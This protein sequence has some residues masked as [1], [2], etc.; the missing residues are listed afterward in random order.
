MIS[1]DLFSQIACDHSEDAGNLEAQTV[2]E[3][4]SLLQEFI[5]YIKQH[6]VVV[7]EELASAF[8]LVRLW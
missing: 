5:A 3:S 2:V 6:K 1:R 8:N 4:Q 7:L